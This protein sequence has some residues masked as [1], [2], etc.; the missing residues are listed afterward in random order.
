MFPWIWSDCYNGHRNEFLRRMPKSVLQSDWY[1]GGDFDPK[2]SMA[3][4]AYLQLDKAGFDQVPCGSNWATDAIPNP[5]GPAAIA[6]IAGAGDRMELVV[7]AIGRVDEICEVSQIAALKRCN[8][9]CLKL[10]E[11]V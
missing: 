5:D 9:I 4:R 11:K 10:L 3:A 2:S 6:A 1:Y 8:V 7:W